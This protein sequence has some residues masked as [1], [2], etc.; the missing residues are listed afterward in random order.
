MWV[1]VGSRGRGGKGNECEEGGSLCWRDEEGVDGGRLHW[2]R[3][4]NGS[5][6]WLGNKEGGDGGM[7]EVVALGHV[8]G[9]WRLQNLR[10]GFPHRLTD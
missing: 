8:L 5:E 6:A 1:V 2:W 9:W 10:R 7:E 4:E 3:S